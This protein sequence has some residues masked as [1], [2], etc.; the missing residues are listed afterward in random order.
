MSTGINIAPSSDLTV[1]TTAVTSG[2]NGRVFFQAGGVVQQDANFTYN[3][4]LE[5]L[6]LK[7]VGTAAADIPFVVRNSADT[8]N[9]MQV[10]G[11]NTMTFLSLGN[12]GFSSS[13]A[14]GNIKIKR[15]FSSQT[16]VELGG[17]DNAFI[18][19]SPINLPSYIALGNSA[20]G[21]SINW[22]V[23]N[24]HFQIKNSFHNL[25]DVTGNPNTA[26]ATFRIGTIASNTNFFNVHG[27]NAGG[28]G[29]TTNPVFTIN[30][31]GTVGIGTEAS[32]PGARLDVR[33]QGALSTDIAFRVRNSADS[34]DMF[35]VRG[36]GDI[37]LPSTGG[38]SNVCT[39]YANLNDSF[40]PNALITYGRKGSGNLALNESAF[41]TAGFFGQTS[42]GI[43]AGVAAENGLAIGNTA[44]IDSGATNGISIG[45]WARGFGTNVIN[46]GT[47]SATNQTYGGTNS[48]YLGNKSGGFGT[49]IDN[50]M[51][52]YFASNNTSTITRGNGSIG[53]L[54]QQVEVRSNGT[55][56]DGITTAMGNGGNTLVVRNHTSVPSTN[57]TDSF[58]QYS[59]DITTGNAAPHFRTENGSIIKL[60]QNTAVTTTQGVANALTNLGVLA[61]STIAPTVQ[62]VVSA[63]TVTPTFTNDLVKI[64]AQAVA[65]T[66]AVPTGT[67][68]DGKDLMI[69]I[70]DSGSAQTI[71][72]TSG[73]G[74]YRAIGVTLPTTTTAGKTTYV[75]L[76][77]NSDDS[78]WDVIGVT[79][80][81]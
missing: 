70:K 16:M 35:S 51:S 13:D 72:W 73:T 38:G 33:A 76:I 1:G 56:A 39:I 69:R 58:Q 55:G 64:T 60:Y 5:R 80:Q 65:L 78:V 25:F 67:A 59:A 68:I 81:A 42:L 77:Y 66:L 18:S 9:L 31:S 37:Y 50:V 22:D 19:V 2:T 49:N 4:T 34:A 27:R 62:S 10:A 23:T 53:L 45:L 57:I 71:A 30:S 14:G 21:A 12:I 15:N 43:S 6:T 46:I 24:F 3:N 36:N 79:T 41:F 44:R 17:G 8:A 26:L 7:A 63:A 52:I 48:I 29:L 47:G 74:G 61:S 20:N 54:G 75:G 40:G 32:T 11:D 28:T